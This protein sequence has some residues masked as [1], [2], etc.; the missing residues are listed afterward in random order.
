MRLH[1]LLLEERVIDLRALDPTKA[2]QRQRLR[3]DAEDV[4]EQDDAGRLV[5]HARVDLREGAR[6]SPPSLY[7]ASGARARPRRAP[8]AS[9]D[10]DSSRRRTPASRAARGGRAFCG[11]ARSVPSARRGATTTAAFVLDGRQNA[12]FP[13]SLRHKMVVKH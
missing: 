1:G 7:A 6:S 3:R 5:R 11:A 4:L 13:A 8:A 12:A 9:E 10:L 2:E